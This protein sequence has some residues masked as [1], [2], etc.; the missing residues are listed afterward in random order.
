MVS[1]G[2]LGAWVVRT[3]CVR[4]RADFC[5]ML[6]ACFRY[7]PMV[8]GLYL[9]APSAYDGGPPTQIPY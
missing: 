8:G 4:L 1:V 6:A 9:H 5:L 7:W 3:F 2:K